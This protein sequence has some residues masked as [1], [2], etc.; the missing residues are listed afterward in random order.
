MIW[1]TNTIDLYHAFEK[2]KHTKACY[3]VV[4]SPTNEL[5]LCSAGLD[6][7][8]QFFDIAE[9]K[10]VKSISAHEPISCLSFYID[11]FTIAAGTLSGQIY[12]YNLKDFKIK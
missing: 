1:D 6:K 5:L 4:F 3:G 9:K 2:F 10:N 11:G 8:I 7:K 12:V